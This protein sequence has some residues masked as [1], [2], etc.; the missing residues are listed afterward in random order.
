MYKT[1]QNTTPSSLSVVQNTTPSSVAS[2]RHSKRLSPCSADAVHNSQAKKL[3]GASEPSLL[4]E[5]DRNEV[6][7]ISSSDDGRTDDEPQPSQRT[8]V[9]ID[10]SQTLDDEEL[11]VKVIIATT[12]IVE[13]VI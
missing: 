11:S 13:F 5:C 7:L 9:V 4:E 1:K 2:T 12:V 8:P 6:V 3:R 10:L